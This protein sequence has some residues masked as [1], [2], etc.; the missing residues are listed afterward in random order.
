M[1]IALVLG[2]PLAGAMVLAA[3][4]QRSWAPEVNALASLGTLIAAAL[5]T[6]RVI[7]DGPMTALNEQVFVDPF[8]VFL[9]ALTAF[10][11]FTTALF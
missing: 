1:E 4:G 5:L 11:A 7:A 10:V 6:G 2:V 3:F 8:N 9:V